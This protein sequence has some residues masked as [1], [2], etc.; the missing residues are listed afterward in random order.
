MRR[1]RG[2]SFA[3]LVVVLGI[4]GIGLAI[5]LNSVNSPHTRHGPKALANVIAEEFRLARSEAIASGQPVGVAI[6]APPSPAEGS[7]QSFYVLKGE[8]SPR[9]VRV[10]RT[11]SDYPAA[12][13]TH[14]AWGD[15][16]A[17]T[18]ESRL[19]FDFAKW[20]HPRA[21]DPTLIFLPSGDVTSNYLAH[22]G[23][24]YRVL[25]SSGVRVTANDFD[26]PNTP[27]KPQN[28]SLV[29][30]SDAF[31]VTVTTSGQVAVDTGVAGQRTLAVSASHRPTVSAPP[32]L[33]ATSATAPVID[34]FETLPQSTSTGLPQLPKEEDLTLEIKAQGNG[35]GPLF[36]NWQ[37]PKGV[38]STQNPAP[39]AWDPEEQLW[40]ARVDFRP[41]PGLAPGTQVDIAAEVWDS[42]DGSGTTTQSALS[43]QT[44]PS[45]TG[46]I[47]VLGL[48]EPKKVPGSSFRSPPGYRLAFVNAK[49]ET[50]APLATWPDAVRDLVPSPDGERF[51]VQVDSTNWS[52]GSTDSGA[53]TETDFGPAKNLSWSSDGI[54]VGYQRGSRAVVRSVD[55]T[56]EQDY[57]IAPRHYISGWR[58]D[59]SSYAASSSDELSLFDVDGTPRATLTN[60]AL[61]SPKVAWSAD[62]S[63]IVYGEEAPSGDVVL[64]VAAA[65]GSGAREVTRFAP[66]SAGTTYR[67]LEFVW[68]PDGQHFTV[69]AGPMSRGTRTLDLYHK[70]TGLVGSFSGRDFGTPTFTSDSELVY[71]A[72][73]DSS[74]S[75]NESRKVATQFEFV[76]AP[77]VDPGTGAI[78]DRTHRVATRWED[79][80][81]TR[82]VASSKVQV[83]DLTTGATEEV[84]NQLPTVTSLFWVAD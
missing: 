10:Q 31:T 43:F 63:Q 42:D 21:K 62:G 8:H 52:I 68:A 12:Y 75:Y 59:L 41:D 13:L 30:A 54:L 39:M 11:D 34:S 51:L 53:I 14:A 56:V 81:V 46:R 15:P 1:S 4:L 33:A 23:S 70:D 24:N 50:E 48:E 26:A 69:G 78:I 36:V 64:S 22:D 32:L 47:L 6:P 35:S 74:F 60:S 18:T 29:E 3:E 9:I 45:S 17:I 25:I 71:S 7:S 5:I 28:H 40:V 82:G 84:P 2:F 67:R 27:D 19:A 73:G 37:G 77:Y 72:R 76:Q 16:A 80:M 38:F 20:G 55:G 57:P 49:G 66:R 83:L 65:D 61:P 79:R 58:P 44:P